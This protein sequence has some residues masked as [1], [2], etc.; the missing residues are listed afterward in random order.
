MRN[1]ATSKST[2]CGVEPGSE[3]EDLSRVE[4]IGL[5]TNLDFGFSLD[6]SKKTGRLPEASGTHDGR[7][8]GRCLDVE[9]LAILRLGE[10][11]GAGLQIDLICR[12]GSN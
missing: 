11:D 6:D 10:E 9:L 1:R 12:D 7:R 8:Y 3:K 4:G 2:I 5:S